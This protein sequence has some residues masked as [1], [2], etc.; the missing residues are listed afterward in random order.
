LPLLLFGL[1]LLLNGRASGDVLLSGAVATGIVTLFMR[2][3]MAWTIARD[4]KIWKRVWLVISYLAMLIREIFKANG[5]VLK[6]IL[7]PGKKPEPVIVP[8]RTMLRSRLAR[9]ALCNS[10][11][12]TPGTIT[13]TLEGDVITVHCLDRSMA[14]GLEN[15]C[16][17]KALLRIEA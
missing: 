5:A 8:V 7:S 13:L 16:F 4:I 12:L 2:R 9:V 3:Y 10:I 17:E 15:S 11:T 1:W 6:L 14:D